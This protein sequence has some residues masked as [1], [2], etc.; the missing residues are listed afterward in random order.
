MGIMAGLRGRWTTLGRRRQ[1]R[2]APEV[3]LLEGRTLLVVNASLGFLKA[4]PPVL[5]P[6]GGYVT[7]T[8]SGQIGDTHPTPP[9][10]F[11]FVTDE[12]RVVEPH[13]TGIPLTLDHTK[14]VP[15]GP[16]KTWY[17]YSYSFTVELQAKR[18][19][20]TFDGRHYDVFVGA[21]DG[22]GIDG[23]TEQIFVPKVYPPAA[24][25]APAAKPHSRA[26]HGRVK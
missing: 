15:S 2:W 18:S 24:T 1:R 12:Y 25:T 13:G 8:L 20:R 10:A 21:S 17:V 9:S 23:L 14:S 7:V 6:T 11:Y 5:A 19:T 26:H 3:T 4:S 22:D 16:I